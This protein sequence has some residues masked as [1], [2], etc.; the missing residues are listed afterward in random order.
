[1]CTEL[2]LNSN[3]FNKRHMMKDIDF[4]SSIKW[5]RH[6]MRRIADWHKMVLKELNMMR[7]IIFGWKKQKLQ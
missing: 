4:R 6:T 7:H 1:M 2:Q 5:D 3:L